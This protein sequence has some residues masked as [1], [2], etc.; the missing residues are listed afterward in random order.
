MRISDWSSDVCSS[1]LA[2]SHDHNQRHRITMMR[3]QRPSTEDL[4]QYVISQAARRSYYVRLPA[5]LAMLESLLNFEEELPG[6]R[7][8]PFG[9][10]FGRASCSAS[11][12]H[13]V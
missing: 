7:F 1:D 4:T 6:Y 10:S 8:V 13:S 9:S 12:C 11:V 3:T 2:G 5:V